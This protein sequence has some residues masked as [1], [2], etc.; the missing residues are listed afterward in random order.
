M[1]M[2][3]PSYLGETIEY[4]SLHACRSTLEDPT[5]DEG[6]I[7]VGRLFGKSGDG[8]SEPDN[9]E[10]QWVVDRSSR[11][12]HF[13]SPPCRARSGCTK[14]GLRPC[15]HSSLGAGRPRKTVLSPHWSKHLATPSEHDL[16]VNAAS[17]CVTLIGRS[18]LRADPWCRAN[19]NCSTR[20]ALQIAENFPRSRPHSNI[21]CA[22]CGVCRHSS[23][24][25]TF[26]RSTRI[27]KRACCASLTRRERALIRTSS[28]LCV[29]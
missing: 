23:G 29:S 28:R 19:C 12:A 17:W 11:G 1:T 25:M 14:P 16:L 20:P 21:I 2:I 13:L 15:R 3:T 8:G 18:R 7:L 10:R 22:P 6:D 26:A 5:C 4:S 9:E 24:G 27:L